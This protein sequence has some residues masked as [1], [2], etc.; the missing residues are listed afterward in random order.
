M[1]IAAIVVAASLLAACCQTPERL[2]EGVVGVV[3]EPGTWA[4]LILGF[5]FAGAVL[6]RRRSTVS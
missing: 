5:G 2:N 1:R 6:R 3:P 4:L